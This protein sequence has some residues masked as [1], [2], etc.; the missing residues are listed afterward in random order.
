MDIGVVGEIPVSSENI[1]C[2]RVLVAAAGV[3]THQDPST[4]CF[5]LS[6]TLARSHTQ[7]CTHP[8]AQTHVLAGEA[9]TLSDHKHTLKCKP[10]RIHERHNNRHTHKDI[11]AHKKQYH[12][13]RQELF[14]SEG[15]QS[16]CTNKCSLI[17]QTY[18]TK[19]AAR[20]GNALLVN[21]GRT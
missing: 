20:T 8:H 6:H 15:R 21:V 14:K 17:T 12:P 16:C 10:T 1:S 19:T 5:C 3:L 11:R 18:E 7:T 4:P 13:L 9:Q 2:P